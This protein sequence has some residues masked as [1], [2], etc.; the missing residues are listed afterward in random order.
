MKYEILMVDYDKT[1]IE[2]S[3]D[4]GMGPEP[5]GETELIYLNLYLREKDTFDVYLLHIGISEQ[6]DDDE[7]VIDSLK[8]EKVDKFTYPEVDINL[9]DLDSLKFITDIISVDIPEKNIRTG[10]PVQ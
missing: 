5:D 6:D 4:D 9:K 7:P 8:V 3:I 1:H 10:K 2:F